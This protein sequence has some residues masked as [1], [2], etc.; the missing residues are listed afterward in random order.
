[1]P[2][3]KETNPYLVDEL[4]DRA[5]VFRPGEGKV[6]R[7][8]NS[9]MTMKVTSEL[10]N[11]QLGVYEIELDA[12]TDGAPLH[13]HR[14]LD[15]TFIVLEGKLTVQHGT[16]TVE[17]TAG[18]VIYVPRFTPHAFGNRSAAKTKIMLIFNPAEKREGFFYGL[19]RILS[20]P[21]MNK[22]EFLKLYHKYDSYLV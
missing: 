22:E 4:K 17:A 14:F 19:H 7:I 16:E 11:D 10:S 9:S 13:F 2:D 3:E 1:M 6:L 12:N 20:A 8:G 18:T 15:E 21:S 5:A